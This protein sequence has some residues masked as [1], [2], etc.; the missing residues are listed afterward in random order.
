MAASR[1][2]KR[3]HIG[4]SCASRDHLAHCVVSDEGEIEGVV[5]WTGSTES[6]IHTVTAGAVLGVELIEVTDFSGR[7]PTLSF[8]WLSW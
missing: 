6:P 7:S 4:P 8:G 1:F 3:G 5:K 2:R